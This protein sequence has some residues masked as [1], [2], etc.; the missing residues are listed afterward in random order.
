MKNIK[1]GLKLIISFLFIVATMTFMG[2][3]L[4]DSLKKLNEHT[5]LIYEEGMVPLEF[6]VETAQ[7]TQEMRM[8]IQ[9]WQFAKTNEERAFIIRNIDDSYAT[10]KDRIAKLKN[11]NLLFAIS[12][13]VVEAHNFA[14]NA[15]IDSITGLCA[16]SLS[17]AV[18]NAANEMSKTVAVAIE[19]RLNS[20]KEFL[21]SNSQTASD[22]E[23]IATAILIIILVFSLCFAIFLT[24][25]ITQPLRVV[26]NTLSKIE[27]GN[28]T[29]R[30]NLEREDEFGTLSKSLD[31]LSE[32][33]Q[34]IFR[35]LRQNSD[36]LADEAEELSDI[37]KQ[38][39][40]ATEQVNTNI[41]AMASSAEEASTNADK[42]ANTAE[43]M[44]AN[45]VTITTAVERMSTSISQ[46]ANNAFDAS[47]IANEATIKSNDATSAMD[48]L[49]AAAEEIGQVTD[50]IKKIADKTNLLALNATIEAASA[51]EA[52][53]GFAVVAGEV[54]ELASQ[55]AKSADDIARRIRG[56]QIGTSAAV[57]VISDVSDII[58][59]INQSIGIIS[60]HVEQQ[61]KASAEIAHHVEQA[62]VGIKRVAESIGE[63]ARGSKEMSR[64]IEGV[65]KCS[66]SVHNTKQINEGA[67]KLARLASDLKGVLI[68]L[69]L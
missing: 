22:S 31:G 21:D 14:E 67:N 34:T 36:T 26:V 7:Q 25:S 12:K 53:K 58:A 16:E 59:K 23:G 3:F 51:G 24:F 44:S 2:V 37:G 49:G 64:N 62:N 39:A 1:I 56:I 20:A 48:K 42:V 54:K 66:T 5:K 32:K 4:I 11:N 47:K 68:K 17:P 60:S 18:L 57:K 28:M 30:A 50:A 69:S 8:N 41:N 65:I 38:V 40:N 46:I 45:M 35:N 61:T 10:L 55:S 13:Y 29:V 6:L 33:L 19:M 9:R 27:H 15:K 63:V 43:Q 52:G